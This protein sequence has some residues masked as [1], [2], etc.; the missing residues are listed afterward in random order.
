MICKLQQLLDSANRNVKYALTVPSVR[1]I[2]ELA[3]KLDSG[4]P[5][6]VLEAYCKSEAAAK[7]YREL[8]RITLRT[9][10]E[11]SFGGFKDLNFGQDVEYRADFEDTDGNVCWGTFLKGTNRRHG[12]NRCINAEKS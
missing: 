2:L 11:N 6:G 12:F 10:I 7:K 3:R 4:F 1:R 5:D 9:I 8:G